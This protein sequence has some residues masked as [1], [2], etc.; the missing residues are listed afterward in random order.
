MGFKSGELAGQ[1]IGVIPIASKTDFLYSEA[2]PHA[3][4]RY[5]V[6]KQA[7]DTVVEPLGL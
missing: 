1:K 5:I 4:L 3:L 7:Q 2:C 6:E